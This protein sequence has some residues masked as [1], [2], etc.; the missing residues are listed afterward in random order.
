MARAYKVR[1]LGGWVVRWLGGPRS[2]A[3]GLVI[4]SLVDA[5]PSTDDGWVVGDKSPAIWG[6]RGEANRP[7][8]P[9]GRLALAA[10][11]CG[12]E[13]SVSLAYPAL[14]VRTPT[15]K[16]FYFTKTESLRIL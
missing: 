3:A 1:W 6:V 8:V 11:G 13:L 16:R 5:Q 9:P 2:V 14:C 10:N 7:G 15:R 12:G 4:G